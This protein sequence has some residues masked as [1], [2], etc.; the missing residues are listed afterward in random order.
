M[1]TQFCDGKYL[2]RSNGYSTVAGVVPCGG[3]KKSPRI[4]SE[5]RLYFISFGIFKPILV[6]LEFQL[7]LKAALGAYRIYCI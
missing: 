3:R 5:C 6:I 4:S 1:N 2:L 7:P